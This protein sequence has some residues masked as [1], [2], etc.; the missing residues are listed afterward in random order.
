MIKLII[1]KPGLVLNIPGIQSVRTPV[2]VDITK[3]NINLVISEL[4]KNGIHDYKIISGEEKVKTEKILTK[5]T[6]NLVIDH[7]EVL[8]K[9]DEV[10]EKITK[11]VEK[12]LND[13]LNSQT[14]NTIKEDTLKQKPKK[15]SE[16]IEEDFI[17]AINLSKI[18][19][20]SSITKK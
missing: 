4:K 20:T 5:E 9:I 18:K 6:N 19:G 12:I 16:T 3:L 1:H 7:S 11:N 2:E 13:F 15:L 8:D 10:H 17:P 14:K